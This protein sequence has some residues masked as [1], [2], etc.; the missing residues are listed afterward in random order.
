MVV[1]SKIPNSTFRTIGQM[2]IYET[3]LYV[4]KQSYVSIQSPGSWLFISL[5]QLNQL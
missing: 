1:S 2:V 3:V 5:N 4:C